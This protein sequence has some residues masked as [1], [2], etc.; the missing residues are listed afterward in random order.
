MPDFH[1]AIPRKFAEN[2]L[3]NSEA[4]IIAPPGTYNPAAEFQLMLDRDRDFKIRAIKTVQ[5]NPILEQ[6]TFEYL[7]QESSA[8]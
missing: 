5:I 1:P 8:T 4:N 7:D 2:P 6:F 3:L